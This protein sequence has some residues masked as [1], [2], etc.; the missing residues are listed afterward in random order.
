ML[1]PIIMKLTLAHIIFIQCYV[2]NNP[3]FS[4]IYNSILQGSEGPSGDEGD[5]GQDAEYCPCP[6]RSPGAAISG[7]A[8]TGE[9]VTAAAVQ[10][11]PS[12][13]AA[14]AYRRKFV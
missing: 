12:K 2:L 4:V 11:S 10:A 7:E 6:S 9:A 5:P 13:I 14:G 3:L 8:V 1:S